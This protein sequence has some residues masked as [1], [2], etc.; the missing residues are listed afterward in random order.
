MGDI[1]GCLN[2]FLRAAEAVNFDPAA[3]RLFSVGDLVDRGPHSLEML[4]FALDHDWFHVVPGNHEVMCLDLVEAFL[5]TTMP[6]D[7]VWRINPRELDQAAENGLGWLIGAMVGDGSENGARRAEVALRLTEDWPLAMEVQL[8]DGAFG[9]LHADPCNRDWPMVEAITSLDRVPHGEE[10][11]IIWGRGDI[12]A[13]R[14]GASDMKAS[15]RG[16]TRLFTGHTV[17]QPAPMM[18]GNRVWLDGGAVFGN[19]E[20]RLVEV[21]R[22]GEPVVAGSNEGT[23][24]G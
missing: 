21:S 6:G 8:A 18:R 17:V 12:M 23:R 13:I 3:D 1:H 15:V 9:V 10:M 22:T 7:H 24:N 4:E 14:Q 2:E 11:K 19:D 16:V 20:L 5:E